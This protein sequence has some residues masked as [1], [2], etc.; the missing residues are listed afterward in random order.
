MVTGSAA[1]SVAAGASVAAAGASVATG[2]SVAAGVPQAA[3]RSAAMITTLI[4]RDNF[5]VMILLLF[6]L[7]QA[8]IE[9]CGEHLHTTS[10]VF[11]H[12]SKGREKACYLFILSDTLT[13]LLLSVG[14]KFLPMMKC[15]VVINRLSFGRMNV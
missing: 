7:V 3:S 1:A 15:W 12:L 11:Y 9:T 14:D 10:Q 8:I 4:N 2:A 6:R 5:L 13:S